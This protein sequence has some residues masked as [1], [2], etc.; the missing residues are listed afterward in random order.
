MTKFDI[1]L[2]ETSIGENSNGFTIPLYRADGAKVATKERALGGHAINWCSARF[3]G[4]FGNRLFE[5]K[6]AFTSEQL[7]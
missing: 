2:V 1:F 7:L 6:R 5:R 3:M 4:V